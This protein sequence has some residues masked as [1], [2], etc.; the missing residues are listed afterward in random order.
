M[1]STLIAAAL[2]LAAL[3]GA[4][5]AASFTPA[6]GLAADAAPAIE[7]VNHGGPGCQLGPRGWH[8]HTS[9]G[10][11]IVCNPRPAGSFYGWRCEGPRCGWW[12]GTLRRWY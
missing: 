2:A 4:A 5:S 1:K 6:A 12:H 3:S 9:R 7:Q 10:D 11:R 8:Y